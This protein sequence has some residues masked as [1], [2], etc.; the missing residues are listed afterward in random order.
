M[1]YGAQNHSKYAI[2]NQMNTILATNLTFLTD[3]DRKRSEKKSH[4]RKLAFN[5]PKQFLEQLI[6]NFLP[7]VLKLMSTS[8]ILNN[9]SN[10]PA[11]ANYL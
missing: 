7:L 10:R 8:L 11:N 1:N 5:Y 3:S 6:L 4:L 2:S 9:L